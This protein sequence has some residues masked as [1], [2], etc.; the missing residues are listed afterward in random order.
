[1]SRGMQPVTDRPGA[2]ALPDGLSASEVAARRQRGES[3]RVRQ[4]TGCSFVEQ[5]TLAR[6]H[7]GGWRTLPVGRVA[8]AGGTDEPFSVQWAATT[9]TVERAMRA[10]GWQAVRSIP[11]WQVAQKSSNSGETPM[12]ALKVREGAAPAMAFAGNSGAAPDRLLV[13]G[14]WP[15]SARLL[16]GSGYDRIPVWVGTL[17]HEHP[18]ALPAW[19]FSTQS[20]GTDFTAPLAEF[21]SRFLN[22]HGVNRDDPGSSGFRY[23]DRRVRL[24][25]T[26]ATRDVAYDPPQ[27]V[28]THAACR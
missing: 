17:A 9:T 20:S 18:E 22:G 24:V 10:P 16:P 1:M 14:F 4:Q 25:C 8:V 23:W 28:L 2:D 7:A 5:T 6:W 27:P 26:D 15:A 11:D 19:T 3:N 21:A 12:I 13:T